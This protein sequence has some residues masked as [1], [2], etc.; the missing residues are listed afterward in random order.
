[1]LATSREAL[2]GSGEQVLEVPPLTV[3]GEGAM[4]PDALRSI[5]A[6]EL[7]VERALNADADFRIVDEELPLVARICRR[8]DGLPLAIEMVAGWAGLLGLE[9]LDAK[10]DGSLKDWL[11]ARNTAPPRH[12]TLRATLEWSHALLSSTGQS[13]LSRLAVFAGGFTM[14]AAEA[15]AAGDDTIPKEQVFETVASLI[16]KSMIAVVPGSRVQHYRLLETT[17]AFMLEKLAA[18]GDANAMRQRH[19]NY[20]LRVLE[21]A[22]CELETTSDAVWL[23][24]YGPVLDDLRAALDWT[25]GEESD[26]AVAL[27]GASWPLWRQLSLPA[28]GGQRLGAAAARLRPGTPVALEARLRHGL[29]DMLLNTSETKAAHREL[30]CAASLYRALHELP[31]LGSALTALGWSLLMLGRIEEAEEATREALGL[32][33]PAG[34]SRTLATAYSSQLCVEAIRGRFDAAIAAGEKAVRL[35]E[36]AGAGRT[37]VLVAANLVQVRMESGDVDG[38]ISAGRA[39]AVRLRETHHSDLLGFVLGVLAGAF[40]A[41]SDLNEALTAAREAAP[42]LREDGRLFWLFDHL[43]LRAALAGRARDAAL[44][45]GYSNAV[46]EKSARVREPMGRHAMERMTPLLRDAL[47]DTEIA[48]LERLGARLSEEQAITIALGA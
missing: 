3:P 5:A 15:V 34:W 44:V 47:P 32:L 23:E 14:E 4:P 40:T 36:M 13:V 39:V 11:R 33:E 48:Q 31:H 8:V 30:D 42:L 35:S 43:A 28:E 25:M 45:A 10:L 21:T 41:R 29:G 24:R 22:M 6:V 26:D 27:A 7:F 37:A 2:S 20:V 1:I 9:M 18:S 16:R 12:S 17:R 46:H 38:A 19:A